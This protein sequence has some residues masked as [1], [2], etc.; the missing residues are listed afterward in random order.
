ME[1]KTNKTKS[2]EEVV[3]A[4]RAGD[5]L[6]INELI[7]LNEKLI[8]S[9]IKEIK[10]ETTI[11]KEDE[12]DLMQIGR[13]TIWNCA[14]S[15]E[16][17]K[18]V[19]FSTY[20]RSKIYYAM[21]EHIRKSKVVNGVSYD[22]L[23]K[24]SKYGKYVDSYIKETGRKPSD[25]EIMS[26]L[27]ISKD[28]LL[29]INGAMK[30]ANAESIEEQRESDDKSVLKYDNIS[31]EIDPYIEIIDDI[32]EVWN[33]VEKTLSD[34]AKEIVRSLFIDG[35]KTKDIAKKMGVTEQYI[36][37]IKK[38]AFEK[39]KRNPKVKQLAFDR[40]IYRTM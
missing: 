25:E 35:M 29:D 7:I 23:R 11:S 39:L 5:R 17:E 13:K 19:L 32:S 38:D 21:K 9:V 36:T 30:H 28:R 22:L 34:K 40:G 15:F 16:A 12:E 24:Q 2:N 4:I 26:A 8:R 31:D 18:G 37:S 14:Y 6:V 27:G 1:N 33:A 20:T 3:A 10:T